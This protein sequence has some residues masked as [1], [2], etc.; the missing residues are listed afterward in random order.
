M[1]TSLGFPGLGSPVGPTQHPEAPRGPDQHFPVSRQSLRIG[2][3][4]LLLP[5]LPQTPMGKGIRLGSWTEG[6]STETEP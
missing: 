6:L 4:T 2:V 3:D 5:L 1:I